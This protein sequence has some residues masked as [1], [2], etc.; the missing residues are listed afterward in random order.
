MKK[1]KRPARTFSAVEKAKAVLSVWAERRKPTEACKE[2][3]INWALLN[4]WQTR[5]LAGMLKGLESRNGTDKKAI[6]AIGKR[7]QNLLKK[8]MTQREKTREKLDNR[9][10]MIQQKQDSRKEQSS[11]QK[12]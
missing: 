6:P 4:Y 3:G 2:L 9:L 11:V 7:L 10:N 8:N 5:A 12:K 1:E